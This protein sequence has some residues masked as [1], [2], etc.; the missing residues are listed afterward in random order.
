MSLTPHEKRRQRYLESQGWMG[1]TNRELHGLNLRENED[2][3]AEE[4][5]AEIAA[6]EAEGKPDLKLRRTLENLEDQDD[7]ADDSGDY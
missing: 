3:S 5:R 4:L 1:R 7:G 2:K 6:R